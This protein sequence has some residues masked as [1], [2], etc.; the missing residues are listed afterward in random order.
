MGFVTFLKWRIFALINRTEVF[1]L[2]KM[3]LVF[4]YFV[5]FGL[6]VASA[7]CK[8]WIIQYF[9]CEYEVRQPFKYPRIDKPNLFFGRREFSSCTRTWND[10]C[11]DQ[12]ILNG[13]PTSA[14]FC[15]FLILGIP[16][17]ALAFAP[18]CDQL[19][20]KNV[21]RYRNTI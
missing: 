7:S 11:F 13:V 8:D 9:R 16:I 2:K 18:S 21:N 12:T 20:M 3:R 5:A 1:H 4:L 10:N 19:I 17:F 14:R 6:F 15:L